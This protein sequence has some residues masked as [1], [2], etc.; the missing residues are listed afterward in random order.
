[1]SAPNTAPLLAGYAPLA[2]LYDETVA[3]GGGVRPH[4]NRLIADLDELGPR[5]LA[6]RWEQAQ[7]QIAGDGV[8]FN[9]HDDDGGASRPWVLDA[10][11]LVLA[12]DEWN[13]VTAGLA[14][15]ARL[16]DLILRDLFGPQHLLRDKVLPPDV[17]FGNPA[18]CPAYEG[19]HAGLK[20]Q[21][22]LYGAD[23][24][25]APDGAWHVT[26]DRTRAPFGLGY[27]L[28][29]RIVTSRMLPRA[30]REC[31]AQRLAPFFIQLRETLREQAT[32]FRDNPRIALWTK[33]PTSRSYFEDAYLARYLGYTLAEGGDL[34]VRE[35]R[36]MLKTLGGLLPVE[37]LL[38]RLDDEDCDPVELNA[39]SNLGV[40]GLLEVVRSGNVAIVNPLGSRIAES[41]ILEAFLPAA[42]RFFLAE[43]LRLPVPHTW[44]CGDAESMRS[45]L[46]NLDGLVIRPAFRIGD[47]KPI[48]PGLLSAA[49]K[50]E[51]VQQLRSRPDRYVAQAIIARSTTP[52]WSEA[53]PAPW[54][55]ALRAFLVS[56]GDGYTALP[57]GLA[58]ISTDATILDDAMT[59]GERSQ[60]VW[61][62]SEKPVPP[63]SLLSSTEDVVTLR[64]TG[65]E[66]PSRVADN[67][68]WLGR[69]IERAEGSARLVRT[70][71]NLL[72]SESEQG[73]ELRPLLRALAE[74][75]QI[76]PDY[77]VSGLSDPLPD[78]REILPEAV[79]DAKLQRSVR[80]SITMV[81][82]LASIVRDRIAID[83]WRTVQQIEQ[84]G[85][86]PAG[87]D[88]L[89]A[90][91]VLGILDDLVTELMA[92]AGLAAESMTRTQGW[93]FLDLGR[94]IERT[95]QTAVLLRSTLTE[96]TPCEREVL[97][98]VLQTADSIMTY[99]SRY[100]ATVQAPAVLDLLL[101]DETN[102]RSIAFQLEVLAEHV[103]QLPRSETQALRSPEQRMALALLNAVRLADVFELTQT[104][105]RGEREALD[106]LLKR[107]CDQLPRF[108]DAVSGRFLIHA[109]LPRHFG[110]AET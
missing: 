83:M 93:R 35:N 95:W 37:V 105:S 48:R 106:R 110:K 47:L 66:L 3:A 61:V 43:D 25:R 2:G 68:Y 33:G 29:N 34:A 80:S 104:N 108:S 21:L 38:R 14:Q 28:E 90:A 71:L 1:M 97:E 76:E 5:E 56:S 15:R 57:G 46:R 98:A 13:S 70:V 8:T 73:P 107:L 89:D 67:L 75:G 23:L 42:C 24:A 44:W 91:A 101:T 54:H 78:V 81:V 64:R 63:V 6:R 60:D 10:I 99:R 65:A 87:I 40:S 11:P 109:G 92:F 84:A 86:R 72:T 62:L 74:Q 82:K 30:F 16:L 17:L 4:W 27:V 45:V 96:Q 50:S 100:L 79:F 103:D 55:L 58:R 9:P 52:C 18:Y 41:P 94:R 102:P 85:Q 12:E 51:L 69:Y 20:R 7:R 36:V 77:A 49:A 88:T 19:L 53:G 31:R 26:G 39:D 59:S 22:H 32:R